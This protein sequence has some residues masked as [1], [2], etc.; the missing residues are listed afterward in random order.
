MAKILVVDDEP[1]IRKA[2]TLS[3]SGDGHAVTEAGSKPAALERLHEHSFDIVV[4]DL[5]IPNETDGLEILKTCKSRQ[6][7][8]MVIMITAHGSI[9]RAVEAVKAGADDFIAKGFTMEELK[10]RL[11]KLREQK[12][13]REENRRLAE[14]YNR[15]QHEIEGRYRFAQIIGNSKAIRELLELLARVVDDRDTTVLLQGESG[16]G[17]ELVARA[18]HYSGPR[19]D[20]PFVIVNCAALPE[21][22]L[23]SELFGYEKGAFTGAL[24][25]KPGKFEIADD[26]TIFIDEVGEISPKVQVELLRFTQDHTFERV[27]G[28]QPMTVDVRIIA[29]TNK[30]LDEEVKQGRFRAD[31]FY[32]LNVIPLY[33][34]PLRER[35]EDIPLLAAHFVEKFRR[36][37]NRAIHLA[38]ET[39]ARLEKHDWPGNVRELENLIERLVVTAPQATILPIDLPPENFGH[40]E[41][42]AFESAMSQPS[43]QEARE[44]F[45]KVFLL[46]HLEKHRWNITEVAQALGERRDTLSRK[47]KRYR[48]K[49]E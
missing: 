7:E 37:K 20:K 21:H 39:L 30:R 23:E 5:F 6:P 41:K 17:K 47:I 25:D 4:T 36:E 34:P 28:N 48:L 26:G 33:V 22:L 27:G 2:L 46:R 11:E 12:R 8:A 44:E 49:S 29:A 35:R 15:L 19:K 42:E 45:E 18:I 31:L 14:N 13:L 38:P 32:R 43:L 1:S 3:L 16:T 40:S 9:E 10:L 24:R